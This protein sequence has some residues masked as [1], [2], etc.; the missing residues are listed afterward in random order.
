M[1]KFSIDYIDSSSF[2]VKCDYS[3]KVILNAV[4]DTL[5][6]YDKKKNSYVLNA[7][8][9]YQIKGKTHIIKL[10]DDLYFSD[11]VKVTAKDYIEVIEKYKNL[12]DINIANIYSKDNMLIITLKNNDQSLKNKLSVYLFAPNK[13]KTSGRY[14]ISN[15][16]KDRIELLPNK[17]YR[18]KAINKLEFIKLDNL[19]DNID[20][21][22]KKKIDITNNT[23]IKLGNKNKQLEKSG[24]IFSLE[25]STKFSKHT[26][27]KIVRSINKN[28]LIKA[29]GNSYYIKNDFFFSKET[30]YKYKK[31]NNKKRLK[32]SLS[33]NNFYPNKEIALLIKQELENNN[34]EI[35][36]IES[37][38]D[39]FKK[40]SI[41]DIKLTLN[42]F[43]YIDDSYYYRSKYFRYVMKRS[44]LYKILLSNNN[45]L[46]LANKLFQ[47]KYLKEPIMSFYSEY[48][49]TKATKNFSFLECN[50]NK[51]ED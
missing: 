51:I 50:Y 21:F 13:N 28:N 29:L 9:T 41:Y 49:T 23:F 16:L 42:Y 45:M 47:R 39:D 24:I 25:I 18:N 31:I 22:S 11:G 1:P 12:F 17:Y 2:F 40:I 36:L 15:V 43:E 32:L 3:N 37:T 19:E 27:K 34:F 35:Q 7:C 10:R 44:I 26:R 46:Y 38:Y 4:T 48:K 5:F 14:Y 6:I 33:Y 30:K 20:N 8:D